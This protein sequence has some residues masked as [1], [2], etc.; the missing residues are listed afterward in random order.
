LLLFCRERAGLE[1]KGEKGV[2]NKILIVSISK[3]AYLG[4][5][6]NKE[7]KKKKKKKKVTRGDRRWNTDFF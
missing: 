4:K 5:F 7:Q 2:K 3:I 6:P 1:K